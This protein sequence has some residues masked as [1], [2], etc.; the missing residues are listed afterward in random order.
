MGFRGMHEVVH[1]KSASRVLG[2]LLPYL[3]PYKSRLLLIA[4]LLLLGTAADLVG[5]YLIGVGVDQFIDPSGAS[6][7]GWLSVLGGG[8]LS[9]RAGLSRIIA[10]LGLAYFF[11]WAMG[12][13]QMRL[14]VRVAQKMLLALRSQIFTRIETLSF[15]FFDSHEAGDLMSRL[16]NDTQVINDV[17]GP[18]L[19]RTLSIVLSLVGI[20]ASM[21][22]LNWRLTLA[23]FAVL[24]FV[25]VVVVF[26]SLRVR[27]AFRRTR[28]TIG[29]VS[30]ELQEN[31]SGVR[32][33]QAFNREEA[34][35]SEFQAV[36]AQNLSANVQAETLG[37]IFMPVLDVLSVVALAS[38][39]GYGGYLVLRFSP[40]LATIGVIVAFLT[41][42]R[43]FYQPI[44]ELAQLFGQLQSALAGS[45][46]I[47]ELLDVE[48]DI[49]EA[50]QAIA[51][52]PLT[53]HVAYDHVSFRYQDDTPVLQDVSAEAAPGQTIAIVGPTGAGKTTLVN[54]LPRFY[55]IQEGRVTVDGY[56]VRDAKLDSLRLQI[57]VVP[58]DTFLF[59][60][61]VMENIRYGRIEASDDEVIAAAKMANA[62]PFI[63]RLPQGYQ[64]QVGE[65]G[66]TLSRGNRQLL[67]IA[68]V[69]LKD[70]RI[71]I[72]DE[73]TSSVDT[74]TELLIQKA[75]NELMKDRTSLVIAHR[76]STVRHAHQILVLN[77]GR[78][79]ERGTH[80]ELLGLG[81]VY[82][83]LYMSQF[84]RQEAV[85]PQE[86]SA[87]DPAEEGTPA[88]T[89]Q[90]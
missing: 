39:V 77:E 10:L 43:R 64:T 86:T 15:T 30:A 70:P 80:E 87:Q 31:I 45:E 52:P 24:P 60:G 32:E 29:Q 58:Q 3:A 37:A 72:L 68:R 40:P 33:V 17:F 46:R 54:L 19:M 13:I 22:A 26:F 35:M 11:T 7:P 36:N 25:A 16:V 50:P 20:I 47:F 62:H 49:V 89:T 73:A 84:R 12:V 78:I 6:M 42:V 76:L 48:P 51:L 81:G 38:V 41:Y 53:G 61:T 83:E 59:A 69:I 34:S 27:A 85:E 14:M 5:P 57:G 56:D 88:A 63:E 74:R 18:G 1:A 67:A 9:R 2:R 44:R 8:A 82:H 79:V 75:L 71:L 21:V 55:D 66:A 90:A 65:R 23:A 4:F 28:Q